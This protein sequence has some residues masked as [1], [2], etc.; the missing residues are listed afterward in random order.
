VKV[1]FLGTPSFAQPTLEALLDS[2]HT[3]LA[4]LTPPDRARGRSGTPSACPVK[5]TALA[6]DVPVLQ[7]QRVNHPDTYRQVAGMAPDVAVV[8]AFGR[9]LSRRFLDLPVHGCINLHAS[10]LPAY[11][12]AAPVQWAM[13]RGESETG[14]TTMQLDEGM[15]TGDILLQTITGIEKQ[16]TAVDLAQRL[17]SLGAGLMVETLDRLEAGN[18][19]PVPQ[20]EEGASR[21]PLLV[22]EDGRLD[23]AEEAGS[24]ANRIRG[25][26]PWPVAWTRAESG[27]LKIFRAEAAGESPPGTEPGTVV[28]V[29]GEDVLVGC[30]E[31]T[32]LSVRELQ[33]DSRRRMSGR[34]AVNG[35]A[36]RVGERLG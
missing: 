22:K 8:V 11:R 25:L 4:V 32:R 20:P 12:G 9:L 17:A 34:E 13:V 30:G 35:R 2:R 15:D 6:R 5:E 21:A 33:P 31:G 26:Q 18:L 28:D 10:L 19:T 7:P 16:E 14:V 1:L 24:L 29:S 36:L 23:W 3:V 27:G